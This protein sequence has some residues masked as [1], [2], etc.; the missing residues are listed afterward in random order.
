M[1]GA[2]ERE[3][4]ARLWRERRSIQRALRGMR[5]GLGLGQ[6]EGQSLSELTTYDNHP[7]DLGTETWQR[8]QRLG[9]SVEFSRKLDDVDEALRKLGEGS[10]GRCDRCGR[11][12]P[13]ERLQARPEAQLCVTCQ[14]AVEDTV[15]ATHPGR[16]VEEELLSPPFGRTWTGPHGSAGF[17]GED[18][19]QEVA[20]FGSS[21][22]PSDVPETEYPEIMQGE[23]ERHGAVEDVELIDPSQVI[24][25]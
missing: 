22:T 4:R 1:D 11:T 10:Y 3:A 20:R 23:F 16:P 21:D 7:A 24:G 13:R 14:Q 17:D 6:T 18:S 8:E 9:L 19:W 2:W 12:I 5:D 15:A 25:P